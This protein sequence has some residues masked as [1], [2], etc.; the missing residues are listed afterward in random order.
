MQFEVVQSNEPG[1]GRKYDWDPV[2]EAL[3]KLK[4]GEAIKIPTGTREKQSLSASLRAKA[5]AQSIK[6]NILVFEDHLLV[7]IKNRKA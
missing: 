4:E 3:P 7:R 5:R 1:I 6:V 2:I